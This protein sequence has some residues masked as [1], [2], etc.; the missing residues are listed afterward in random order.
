MNIRVSGILSLIFII[1]AKNYIFTASLPLPFEGDQNY[2]FKYN[3]SWNKLNIFDW[4]GK[5][6]GMAKLEYESVDVSLIGI[7]R[8]NAIFRIVK[9]KRKPDNT[10]DKYYLVLRGM[11]YEY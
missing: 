10:F 8:N 11:V 7:S 5:R 9:D 6:I 2:E 4:N 3:F 1:L